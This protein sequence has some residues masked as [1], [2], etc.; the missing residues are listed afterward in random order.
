MQEAQF[1]SSKEWF[2]IKVIGAKQSIEAISTVNSIVAVAKITLPLIILC[3][4]LLIVVVAS[5]L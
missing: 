4:L 3:A 2:D 1:S 5:R